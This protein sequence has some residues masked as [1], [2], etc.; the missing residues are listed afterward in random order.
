MLLK[1]KVQETLDNLPEK[2][3]MDDLFEKMDVID[4]IEKGLEQG[5]NGEFVSEEEMEKI[6]EGWFR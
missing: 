1:S 6:T 5:K 2:F 4:K 3:S